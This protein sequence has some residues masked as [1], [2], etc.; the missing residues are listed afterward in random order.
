MPEE[1]CEKCVDGCECGENCECAP[2]CKCEECHPMVDEDEQV[3]EEPTA[4][5]SA[6][7]AV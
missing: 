4:T 7:E 3:T 6:D 5:P 1:V 2:E